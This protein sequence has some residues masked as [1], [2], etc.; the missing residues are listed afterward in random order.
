[1]S[2]LRAALLPVDTVRFRR[3]KSLGIR[4]VAVVTPALLLGTGLGFPKLLPAA[5][6]ASNPPVVTSVS[7]L[8]GPSQGGNWVKI[9]GSNFTQASAVRFGAVAATSVTASSPTSI[10]AQAPAGSTTVDV[11]VSTIGGISAT[12]PADEYTYTFSNGGFTV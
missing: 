9:T 12:S 2:L 11:T 8:A 6:A 5:S 4:I 1:M 7:P 3:A 10:L